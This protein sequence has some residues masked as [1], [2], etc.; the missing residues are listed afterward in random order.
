MGLMSGSLWLLLCYY[1]GFVWRIHRHLYLMILPETIISSLKKKPVMYTVTVGRTENI[2]QRHW[3]IK[4][5]KLNLWYCFNT[6]WRSPLC[7]HAG[8][9]LHF[10]PSPWI[11]MPISQSRLNLTPTSLQT[12][13]WCKRYCKKKSQY[14]LEN[15]PSSNIDTISGC[16]YQRINELEMQCWVDQ[17]GLSVWPFSRVAHHPKDTRLI[18][19]TN[20]N[21]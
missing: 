2:L 13:S 15:V 7:I 8:S 17:R 3:M 10:S 20:Q 11:Q 12:S 6:R 1:G 5:Y 4:K 9:S 14:V 21:N 18:L 19:H 16:K